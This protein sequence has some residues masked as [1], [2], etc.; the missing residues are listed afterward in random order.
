MTP[1]HW[2]V[3]CIGIGFGVLG[4]IVFLILIGVI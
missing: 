3:F 4:T 1:D 2:F